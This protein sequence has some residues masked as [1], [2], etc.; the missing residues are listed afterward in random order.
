M[1]LRIV[2]GGA[3]VLCALSF[4]AGMATAS[5]KTQPAYHK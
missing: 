4:A 1:M 5:K 2:V 3:V